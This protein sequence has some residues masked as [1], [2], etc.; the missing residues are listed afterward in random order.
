MSDI[1][2]IDQNGLRFEIPHY[3]VIAQ[4]HDRQT[5]S[6]VLIINLTGQLING[7][8]HHAS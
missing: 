3:R 8:K 2:E 5:H 6:Q 7:L 4:D 1:Q